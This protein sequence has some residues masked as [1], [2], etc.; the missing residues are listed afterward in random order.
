MGPAESTVEDEAP[1][2]A[3]ANPEVRFRDLWARFRPAVARLC[4]ANEADPQL[5]RD[6]EQEICVALWRALPHFEER[7]SLRT[8]VFRIA[9]NVAASHVAKRRRD[10]GRTMA[11]LSALEEIP[12]ASEPEA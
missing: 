2:R 12:V 3:S 1:P 5:Q 6:L 8:W 4:R 9:H 11:P 10:R 7:A